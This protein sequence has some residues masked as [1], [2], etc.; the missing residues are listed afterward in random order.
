MCSSGGSGASFAR[1]KQFALQPV[2]SGEVVLQNFLGVKVA[3]VIN[4]SDRA[5]IVAVDYSTEHGQFVLSLGEGEDLRLCA[6]IHSIEVEAMQIRLHHSQDRRP[7]ADVV[8]SV[9]PVV[10]D[11]DMPVPMSVKSLADGYQVGRFPT[12]AT[13]V[14]EAEFAP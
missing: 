1:C 5:L 12:P 7:V 8:V 10:D 2:Q 11:P 9:M 6:G 3:L 13:V 14:V 4:D